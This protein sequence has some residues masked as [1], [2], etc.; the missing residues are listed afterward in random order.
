M[1][2][3]KTKR[4]GIHQAKINLVITKYFGKSEFKPSFHSSLE[5]LFFVFFFNP[6]N[7]YLKSPQFSCCAGTPGS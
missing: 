1:K 7:R 4:H 6:V 3:N 5:L 2:K